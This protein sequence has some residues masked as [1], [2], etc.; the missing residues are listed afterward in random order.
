MIYFNKSTHFHSTFL[1][2]FSFLKQTLR[3]ASHYFTSWCDSAYSQIHIIAVSTIPYAYPAEVV[4]ISYGVNVSTTSKCAGIC[5]MFSLHANLLRNPN[6]CKNTKQT[7][8]IT[9][10]V[11]IAISI[12]HFPRGSSRRTPSNSIEFDRAIA[13]F[14]RNRMSLSIRFQMWIKTKG[15]VSSGYSKSNS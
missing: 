10:S 8:E 7:T 3:F 5:P 14:T 11:D 4:E 2:S 12:P 9:S 13:E 6:V 15:T 1:D